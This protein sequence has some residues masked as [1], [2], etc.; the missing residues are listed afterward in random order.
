MSDQEW[1]QWRPP[2]TRPATPYGVPP[3]PS[4]YDRPRIQED[5]L[6]E[7][8][9]Q[10]E[11]K[12]FQLTLKANLR[13]AFLRISEGGTK[14]RSAIIIPSTGLKEFQ[15]LLGEMIQASESLPSPPPAPASAPASAPDP[16]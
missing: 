1:H 9:I 11:R 6:K 8:F 3:P 16:A 2:V 4:P 13:G 10:C 14:G 15:K 5:T 12:S 7:S